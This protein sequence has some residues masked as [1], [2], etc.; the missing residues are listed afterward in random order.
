MSAQDPQ[1]EARFA[2]LLT[3]YEIMLLGFMRDRYEQT[4]TSL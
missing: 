2:K 3:E 1:R 4:L